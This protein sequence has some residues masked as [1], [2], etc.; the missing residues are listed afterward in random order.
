MNK[1]TIAL[2]VA[3]LVLGA[4]ALAPQSIFAYRGDASVKGPNHSEVRE[5]AIENANLSA[6]KAAC[7]TG[8]MCEVVDTQEELNVLKQMHEA[9]EKGDVATAA[10]LRAKLGLGM[11]NGSGMGQGMGRGR[12]K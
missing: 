5:E 10:Q 2:G 11:R 3:A 8:R 12:N 1:T 6:F 7:V 4:A 9:N